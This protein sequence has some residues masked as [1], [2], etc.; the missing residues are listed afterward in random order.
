MEPHEL[1]DSLS[2]YHQTRLPAER[3]ETS[4][5]ERCYAGPTT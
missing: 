4:A 1:G 5:T 3:H 2:A